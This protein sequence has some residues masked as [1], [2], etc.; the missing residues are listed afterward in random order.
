VVWSEAT[1]S[2]S[3]EERGWGEGNVDRDLSLTLRDFVGPMALRLPS[4]LRRAFQK[5]SKNQHSSKLDADF[6][7]PSGGE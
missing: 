7:L 4:R 6:L 5:P 2:P 3:P 1:K